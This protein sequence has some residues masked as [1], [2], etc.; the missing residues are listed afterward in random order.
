[1]IHEALDF[2]DDPSA[3]VLK[4]KIP[5]INTVPDFIKTAE[6]LSPDEMNK[7]PDDVF[8]LVAWD[9]M[10]KMR[11]FACVDQ[12]NTALSV[13][14]F[15]QNKDL[16]PDEA[17]KTAAANLV[18][19][20]GWYDMA[21]PDELEKVALLG[22]TMGALTM[23]SALHEGHG[24]FK[25][26]KQL[27]AQGVPA[28]QVVKMND[29]T[30]SNPMPRGSDPEK[31]ACLHPYVDITGQSA[32]I[33]IVKESA[34]RYCMVKEGSAR[35][36][37][38]TMGQV[39]RAIEYFEEHGTEFEPFE[40]HNYC[41]K[42][43]SRASDLGLVPPEIVERYGSTKMAQDFHIGVFTRKRMFREGT[44]EHS[45][46]DEMQKTASAYKPEIMATA[47][48]SFDR[49][50]GLD[51]LWDSQIPDP[52][53]TFFGPEKRAEWSYSDGNDMIT[54]ERLKRC[55]AQEKVAISRLFDDDMAAEFSKNPQQIFDSLPRDSK[56][57]IMR[58][59]QSV[60]E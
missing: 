48:E 24:K 17:Q 13:I 42:L 41:T 44:S 51:H 4:N 50:H 47:L 28:S 8:A 5:N 59:S 56:R 7:L 20:C 46:L 11:K 52:Y 49:E 35:Y 58:V 22:A 12:G 16:L 36:P 25:R 29:L 1:M 45:L 23:G 6:R 15:L 39:Q 9:G 33:K 10:E 2:Y 34:E 40:R 14:Y 55:A 43:A 57:I 19:A 32:P 60:E 30:G 53:Y 31:T 21:V 38:D 3:N 18:T 26:Q 27:M 37:I 54:A